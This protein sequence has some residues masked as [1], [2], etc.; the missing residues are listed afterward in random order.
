MKFDF[1]NLFGHNSQSLNIHELY[2]D[3]SSIDPKSL[4]GQTAVRTAT[5]LVP[6]RGVVD[7]F[8]HVQWRL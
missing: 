1:L 3:A 8:V 5:G 4:P 6:G 7:G 2:Q